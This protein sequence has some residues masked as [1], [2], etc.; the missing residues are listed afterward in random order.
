PLMAAYKGLSVTYQWTE[1]TVVG[2]V[3]LIGRQ[4]EASNIGGPILI[5]QMSGRAASEGIVS[6]AL[7]IAILSINLGVI[8]LLPVPVLDGGHLLFFLIEGVL[9]RPLSVKKREIAQQV[10]LYLLILLMGLALYNDVVR[11]FTA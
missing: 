5:A 6:T 4:I 2:I 8:N 3:K 11:L 9:G 10:G 1:L 7:F